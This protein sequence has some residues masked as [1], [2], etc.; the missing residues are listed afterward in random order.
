MRF[1]HRFTAVA[2]LAIATLMLG[3]GL[4]VADVYL[5]AQSS[6]GQAV[7]QTPADAST[8]YRFHHVHLNSV[9]P[10]AAIDFYAAHFNAARDRF[11]GK[12]PAVRAQEKWL[13]FNK[14]SRPPAWPVVSALYHIGW[15]APDMQATYRRLVDRGVR[16]ETP[17]TDIAQVLE[18][19]AGRA[20]FAYVDGPD[21]ALIEINGARDDSFQHVHFLSADPVTTGQWYLKHF[22]ASSTNPNPSREPRTHNGLQI[23]PFM[24]AD[25]DGIRFYWYPKA[26]GQGSY[27]DAWKGRSDFAS[28]RGRVIDHIAF[29][30]DRL[31][32][33][34]AQLEA[35]GVKVLQRPKQTPDRLIRSAFVAAPDGV[36][37]EIVE[38][39]GVRP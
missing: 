12:L 32:R 3:I 11:L 36:E 30:V 39:G 20:F 13:L 25:L 9:N 31:D 6:G 35:D 38:A 16:F 5:R 4:P 19:P 22:N 24:G 10:E 2:G 17:L 15:G 28:S 34:V 37:L 27:P 18:A 23:Y 1:V 14:V 29:S 26:F 21:H 7:Q 8:V 33:A